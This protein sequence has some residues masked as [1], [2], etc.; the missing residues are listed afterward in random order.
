MYPYKNTPVDVC[1][2]NA[3]VF[4]ESPASVIC[5]GYDAVFNY[6]A[7]DPDMDVIAYEWAPPLNTSMTT[8][9][10]SYYPGY[11]YSSPLP[12]VFHNINNKTVSLDPENGFIEFR[13]FIMVGSFTLV[14][15]ATSYK[16][17]IKV[18]EV[19]REF[20]AVLKNCGPSN[21]PPIVTDP[22]PLNPDPT[23]DTVHVGDSVSFVVSAMD[24][25]QCPGTTP[26]VPQT[27][28]L[29]AY[30]DQFGIPVNASGCITPPCATLTPSPT[31]TVPVSG[32]LGI[33]TQFAWKT[34]CD[35]L[36]PYNDN[37]VKTKYRFLF[38]VRDDFCP[39]PMVN[40]SLVT[41][42]VTPK[43]KIPE[44]PPITCVAVH[45]NGDVEI[46]WQKPA[47]S[48]NTFESY[49][50]FASNSPS[51]N[52]TPIDT[53]SNINTLSAIHINGANDTKPVYYYLAVSNQCTGTDRI[54]TPS[55]TVK[56][57]HL[58]VNS[59][60]IWPPV[61]EL[62]WNHPGNPM[63]QGS[64]GIYNIY[65]KIDPGQWTV[66]A[67]TTLTHFNDTISQMLPL[68]EY[69]VAIADTSTTPGPCASLSNTAFAMIDD[70]DVGVVDILYPVNDTLAGS[71]VSLKIAIAN[72]GNDA[73]VSVPVRL[74]IDGMLVTTDQWT[75]TLPPF[76]TFTTHLTFPTPFQPHNTRSAPAQHSFMIAHLP[77]TASARASGLSPAPAQM[78]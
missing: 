78:N 58:K 26:P 39:I 11:S 46:S 9:I 4:N 64:S 28:Y 73:Q 7:R 41:I 21:T 25:G 55:D 40:Y 27:L 38:A 62:E 76:D 44:S 60:S 50:L 66:I 59:L 48:L 24:I 43:P 51:G 61:L 14:V 19:F 56:S 71:Q 12:S 29:T 70:K 36:V 63:L 35:H 34:T 72:F 57:I 13:S 65:R 22:F 2:D 3:P 16:D 42:V 68:P 69:Y 47:D 15:K 10:T 49:I 23:T 53:I 74:L 30:G 54:S 8:P 20:V 1:Y 17:G 32:Q 37:T 77:M 18:S 6:S 52:F 67:A 45:P 33:Q 5:I 75:G 31:S